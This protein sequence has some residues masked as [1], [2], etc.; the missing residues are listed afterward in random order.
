[1]IAC[2][3]ARSKGSS[4]SSNP[5]CHLRNE[6]SAEDSSLLRNLILISPSKFGNSGGSSG[7]P[8][9]RSPHQHVDNTMGWPISATNESWNVHASPEGA[10]DS[11]LR[12]ERSAR[13]R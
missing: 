8:A 7:H 10:S 11:A 1:M 5:Y 3:N 2:H 4:S 13:Y 12:D 9:P 6:A